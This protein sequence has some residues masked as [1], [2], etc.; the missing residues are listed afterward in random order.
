MRC[1]TNLLLLC[2]TTL[3]LGGCVGVS[4]DISRPTPARHWPT[5]MAHRGGTGDAP[6]NTLPAI[7]TALSNGAEAL[8]LTVQ[9]SR[10]GVPVL[11]RPADLSALTNGQGKVADHTLAELQQLNAGWQFK[12]ADGAGGFSYPWRE[13]SLPIPTLIDALNAIPPAI[14]V[15]LD[16]KALPAAPQAAAV[17]HVLDGARA[18]Q[19][20]TLYSTEAAYQQAFAP[21]RQA[22]LYESR[23][24]TRLRLAQVDLAAQC[25]APVVGTRAAFEISRKVDLV[26]TFTLGEGRSSVNARLW[27]PAAV[28]CFRQQGK[29]YLTAI[30]VNNV[31]DLK[32]ATCLGMDAVLVDSP[33]TLRPLRD[34]LKLPLACR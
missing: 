22:Q 18:W 7:A 3:A 24:A 30:A 8:W 12:Q 23:D 32:A 34:S 13:R 26:E 16:M 2:V 6:E 11:Y 31:D 25:N 1:Q 33:A 4:E 15:V 17:A 27:T 14:P 21:Y 9:L 20:V 28:Q 29:V 5:L 19:R 10:D